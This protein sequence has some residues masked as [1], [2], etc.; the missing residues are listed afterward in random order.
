MGKLRLSKSKSTIS[1]DFLYIG[2]I[3]AI[4]VFA[5]FYVEHR[6]AGLSSEKIRRQ[7]H[8]ENSTQA[9][10]HETYEDVYSKYT[11]LD[12]DMSRPRPHKNVSRRIQT[13]EPTFFGDSPAFEKNDVETTYVQNNYI[14][15]AYIDSPH[16]R[17]TDMHTVAPLEKQ[18]PVRNIPQVGCGAT[19]VNIPTRGYVPQY[20]QIGVLTGVGQKI[21]ILPLFGKPIYP[22]SNKWLYFTQSDDYN[23]VRLGIVSNQRKCQGDYGCN[24]LYDDDI[25]TVPPYKQNFKVTLYEMDKLRY[26]PTM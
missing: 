18:I 17:T 23:T 15:Q 8:P 5:Y 20:E 3:L 12:Q 7:P 26:I 10:L 22:G 6:D 16:L 14:D 9:P 4:L 21:R 13:A 24:E 1:K 2:I 19:P 25:V 11:I